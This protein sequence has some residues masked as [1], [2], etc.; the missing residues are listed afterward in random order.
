MS[1]AFRCCVLVLLLAFLVITHQTQAQVTVTA[2]SES[3]QVAKPRQGTAA[4]SARKTE[5][6]FGRRVT[7]PTKAAFFSA[8]LPG[9]GQVYNKKYWKLPLVYTVLGSA[10]AGQVHYQQLYREFKDAKQ[11]RKDNDPLTIDKGKRTASLS[12]NS[13]E[14]Y[15]NRFRPRRDVLISGVAA[16]YGLV[17]L[18]ALVD[19][20][21]RD[22]NVDDNLTWRCSPTFICQNTV[23]A[24]GMAVVITLPTSIRK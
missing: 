22:F 18:D 21:L 5:I 17:I 19:A 20:H 23:I 8:I 7:R 3:S 1:V 2:R 4:D 12:N 24:P 15:L 11:I 13:I 10:V 16:A 9:A 14:F 6:L